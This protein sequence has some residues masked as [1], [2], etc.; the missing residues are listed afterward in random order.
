MKTRLLRKLRRRYSRKYVI[1]RWSGGWCVVWGASGDER[2]RYSNLDRAKIQFR[3]MV[4][5]DI[6]AY[7]VKFRNRLFHLNRRIT[8]YPW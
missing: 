3:E 4:R 2:L 7:V 6:M 1:R 5:D 8:Y